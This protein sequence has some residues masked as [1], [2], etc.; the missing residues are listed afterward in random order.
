MAP[1]PDCDAHSTALPASHCV[2]ELRVSAHTSLISSRK[3]DGEA[4]AHFI[5]AFC[6]DSGSWKTNPESIGITWTTHLTD[7]LLVLKAKQPFGVAFGTYLVSRY[8]C[9]YSADEETEEAA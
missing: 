6:G 9:T 5:K 8:P 7:R 1:S 2:L 3:R 4:V